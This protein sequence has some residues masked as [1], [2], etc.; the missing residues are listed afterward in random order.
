MSLRSDSGQS[1]VVCDY[2]A[3]R[4]LLA[5]SPER[6]LSLIQARYG[7]GI[8]GGIPATFQMEK[9]RVP[10]DTVEINF[11]LKRIGAQ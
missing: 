5:V 1:L 10:P 7:M 6:S 4:V 8:A 3:G 11:V 2:A 9:G